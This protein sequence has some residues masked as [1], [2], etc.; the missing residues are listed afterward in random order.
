MSVLLLE[1]LADAIY[2]YEGNRPP[3][4]AYRNR[5]PGNLRADASTQNNDGAGY[6]V[7]PRFSLGY[8]ALLDDITAKV[9]GQNAHGLG[10]GSSLW[11]FFR[12]YAPSADANDPIAYAAFVAD[13]LSE[14]YPPK[15]F[16]RGMTF[17]DIAGTIGQELP[18]GVAAS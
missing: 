16:T 7:F 4:R 10:P 5:N 1:A 8:T 13:W 18:V 12:I 15:I 2:A 6:R 11:D 17:S 14:T 3:D 9:S